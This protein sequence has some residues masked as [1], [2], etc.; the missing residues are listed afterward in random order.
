MATAQDYVEAFHSPEAIARVSILGVGISR[1][2][3]QQTLELMSAWIRRRERRCICVVPT[4]SI[5]AAYR[6]PRL[7]TVYN[8]AD[9]VLP[10]GMPVVWASRLYGPPLPER[11]TGLDLFPAFC[12][13]AAQE[14]FRMFLLGSHPEVLRKLVQLLPR[15]YP[16][17]RLVGY[18]SPP[19]RPRLREA[20]NALI[21]ERIAQAQPEVLWV[22][23]GAPK[24]DLWIAENL[25]RLPNLIAIGIGAALDAEAGRWR[26]APRWMQRAGLEWLARLVQ[27]PRRLARRY[28]LEAPLFIPLVLRDALG[29]RFA[30]GEASYERPA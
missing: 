2:T 29:A 3:L 5:L 20:D 23:L 14:G 24:Q 30:K 9:L 11:V 13:R 18:Y 10:D 6:D 1:V 8:T 16:G 19:F 25:E 12:A 26:R 22:S 17:L 7:R 21:M 15:R 28:L 4:N 27:E